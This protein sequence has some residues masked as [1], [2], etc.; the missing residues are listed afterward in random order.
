MNKFFSHLASFVEAATVQHGYFS[1]SDDYKE[2]VLDECLGYVTVEKYTNVLGLINVD[3]SYR[4]A[5]LS[6]VCLHF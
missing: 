4:A 3:A 2:K 5:V 1:V 6:V